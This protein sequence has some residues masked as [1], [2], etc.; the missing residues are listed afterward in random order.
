MKLNELLD[1]IELNSRLGNID[2]LESLKEELIKYT[3]SCLDSEK[4]TCNQHLSILN[5]NIDFLKSRACFMSQIEKLKDFINSWNKNDLIRL[6]YTD[7][8]VNNV[9]VELYVDRFLIATMFAGRE[10]QT[11]FYLTLPGPTKPFVLKKNI[12]DNH[13]S[14]L[15]IF[16]GDHY[17]QRATNDNWADI[18]INFIKAISEDF[19]KFV[20]M[21]ESSCPFNK[22]GTHKFKEW[23]T[24]A[25]VE[26]SYEAST[27]L[28]QGVKR[29]EN[30]SGSHV[31]G[32]N[33]SYRIWGK[34]EYVIQYTVDRMACEKPMRHTYTI[35][36]DSYLRELLERMGRS[37]MP[38][39]ILNSKLNTKIAVV[40]RDMNKNPEDR[41]FY[42][43][44][45]NYNWI[46]FLN[47]TF[48]DILK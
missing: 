16:K 46:E 4:T 36:A 24:F 15:Q 44:D 33:G 14:L 34:G 22:D 39:D 21:C 8:Y 3:D 10:I 23:K 37:R 35:E 11:S 32:G 7:S 43:I 25:K 29:G 41:V 5:E 9:G 19:E 17:S 42:P 48:K 38:Y 47:Q 2:K 45:Y 18:I 27:E 40:T 1:D 13:Y 26:I 6:E 12:P 28:V 20:K 30:V 31:V